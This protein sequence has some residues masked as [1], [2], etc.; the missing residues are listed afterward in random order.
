MV[1]GQTN[2]L[3]PMCGVGLGIQLYS[4]APIFLITLNVAPRGPLP[5]G[6]TDTGRSWAS[7]DAATS[8]FR[9][10]RSP[11]PL[12]FHPPLRPIVTNIDAYE[13]TD[14]A[15]LIRVVGLGQR[16]GLQSSFELLQ[17]CGRFKADGDR[18]R[19]Q[20]I[21]IIV[22]ALNVQIA[23]RQVHVPGELR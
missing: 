21:E 5:Q 3:R 10:S 16:R 17:G 20:Q 8:T 19:W 18:L 22:R 13:Q 15:P 12:S 4:S 1:L 6:L 2:T 23:E 14:N 9:P 11:R 7:V